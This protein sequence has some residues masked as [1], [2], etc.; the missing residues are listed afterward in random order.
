LIREK[1]QLPSRHQVDWE[2]VEENFHFR[3]L[4]KELEDLIE[5]TLNE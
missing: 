5:E 2:Y 1:D 4:S 3:N